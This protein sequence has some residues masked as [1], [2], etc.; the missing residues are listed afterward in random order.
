M[1]GAKNSTGCLTLLSQ[2]LLGIDGN[3]VSA[4]SGQGSRRDCTDEVVTTIKSFGPQDFGEL[5]GLAGSHHVVMRA[6]PDL[7][8]LMVAEGNE[9]AESVHR[10]MEKEQARI[11]HALSF[12]SPICNALRDAGKVIVI[13]SLDHWP[14]LGSDLD[15]Y[16]DGRSADVVAIMRD[17]FKAHLEERSWGDRLANKW[18]F[19]VP[20]LPELVEV[21]VGRLGQTGEQVAI[22]ESLV[23][24][25]GTIQLG[26]NSFPV[27]APEERLIIST[28][29][30]MYRH[31]Y[32]RLCDV[33]DTARLVESGRVDYVYLETLARSAGLWDGLATYLVTVSGYV[34]SY[35]GED[36]PL[37]SLVTDAAR[38]GNELVSFRRKFLRI[39]IF[40]QAAKLYAS[41]W[42]RL[43]LNGE[44]QNTLRLSLLPGLAAAA[45]LE[46]KFT[47][48]DKG[49]W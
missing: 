20:G 45:A 2:L 3:N 5:W 26:E 22:A 15:L 40:P 24:R 29:Q 1:N 44:L 16:I 7:Y 10:A 28:L 37:P 49:V 17:R 39:P 38:F 32:L 19:V 47:G 31:F 33:A 6:F 35:R 23:K 21:H 13:K 48:T 4:N 43:L 11:D 25:A 34:K 36:L 18:N 27:P 8:L 30:R 42:A 41:E 14:D 12:L 9:W 46:F